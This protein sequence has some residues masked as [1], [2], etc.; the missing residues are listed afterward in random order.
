MDASSGGPTEHVVYW[1]RLGNT[2]PASWREQKLA[3]A[4]QN[5]RGVIPDAILIR[6][7]TINQDADAAMAAIDNFVRAMLQAV[8]PDRRSV[9]IV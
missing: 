2:I 5:L 1:T 3:V 9:L 4:E 8:P 6:V 7:S